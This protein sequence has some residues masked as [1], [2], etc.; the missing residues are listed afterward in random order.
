MK[1]SMNMTN[2]LIAL[3]IV[4]VAGGVF[5]YMNPAEAPVMENTPESA[6][7]EEAMDHE[8]MQPSDST[9]STN[10][11]DTGS[12]EA[13]DVTIDISGK[14]FE[15][16]QKEIRVKEGDVVKINFT[17]SSGTHDWNVDEFNASTDVVQTGNTSSVTFVADKKG[18]FEYYC[19]VGQHR[20]NGM[21]GKLIVE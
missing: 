3:A 9:G 5:F 19:S 16:S 2:F 17:S 4:I 12:T 14:N 20:A 21:V 10:L 18:E 8:A 15:F 1:D 6:A 13:P 7:T 11:S